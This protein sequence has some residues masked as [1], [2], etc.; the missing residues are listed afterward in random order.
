MA[1]NSAADIVEAVGGPGNIASLTHCAT[2]LRF[3]LHDGAKADKAAAEAV[4]GVLGAVPQAGDRFQVVI[5]GG[6]QTVYNEIMALPVMAG[7][8]AAAGDGAGDSIDDI[9]ARERA[10]GPRGTNA[11]LDSRSKRLKSNRQNA[12]QVPTSR[13]QICLN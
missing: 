2:R 10:K 4:P 13:A 1:S 7:A 11:R 5:G 9:K 12:R 8:A 3:Q 6:V